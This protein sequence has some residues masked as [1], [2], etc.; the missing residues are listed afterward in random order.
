MQSG[1][2]SDIQRLNQDLNA[3]DN[4]IARLKKELDNWM[5]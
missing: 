5:R 1:F 3:R 2:E 4:E